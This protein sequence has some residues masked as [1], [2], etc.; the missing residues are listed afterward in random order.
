MNREPIIWALIDERPGTGNQSKGVAMSLGMPFLEKHLI[1]SN[2]AFLPNSFFGPS[3]IGLKSISKSTI[4][5]PWPD[6]VI[7]SG[8]RAAIVAR[9]IKRKNPQI[10]KIPY[11]CITNF[12]PNS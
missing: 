10:S 3:L 11:M 6:L 8:R 9:Y 4:N 2:L 5:S 1:W 12:R 7:A